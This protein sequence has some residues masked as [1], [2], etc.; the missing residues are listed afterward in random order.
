[1][2]KGY[3]CLNYIWKKKYFVECGFLE[4]FLVDIDLL[5]LFCLCVF[6]FMYNGVFLWKCF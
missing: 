2:K 5:K 3:I 6:G 4:F 1:M